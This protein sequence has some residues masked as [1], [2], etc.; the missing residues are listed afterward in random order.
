MISMLKVN[1]CVISDTGTFFL[2]MLI[3]TPAYV[4]VT[5]GEKIPSWFELKPMLHS[6]ITFSRSPWNRPAWL[7]LAAS[8]V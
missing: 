6:E 8:Q 1:L 5:K 3:T 2:H 7:D 4:E